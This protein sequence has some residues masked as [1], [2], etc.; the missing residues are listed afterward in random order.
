MQA[1]ESDLTAK[2][3][4]LLQRRVTLCMENRELK[5]QMLRLQQEKV[6]VDS[7]LSSASSINH[8]TIFES[9]F[10]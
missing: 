10:N 1:I 7:E 9:E 5:Q 3:A 2:V 8:N 6:I 4:A